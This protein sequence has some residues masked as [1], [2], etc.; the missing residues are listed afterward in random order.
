MC[1]KSLCCEL[2]ILHIL[3]KI[4]RLVDPDKFFFNEKVWLHGIFVSGLTVKER[5]THFNQSDDDFKNPEVFPVKCVICIR[6]SASG[7]RT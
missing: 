6:R 1:L 5:D 2:Y 4:Q 3:L 7:P